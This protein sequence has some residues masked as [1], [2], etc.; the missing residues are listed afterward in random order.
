MHS[1]DITVTFRHTDR[2]NALEARARA[3]I[4]RLSRYND[5]IAACHL[6]IEAKRARPDGPPSFLVKLCISV[7]RAQI[8]ADNQHRPEHARRNL[9]GALRDVVD[10]A[11]RQ[12]IELRARRAAQGRPRDE[13][14]SSARP[15]THHGDSPCR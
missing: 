6:T 8:H 12:L 11:K 2:S 3:S 7:P 14:M 5:R 13:A 9:H 1:P 15:G 10:N 4:R